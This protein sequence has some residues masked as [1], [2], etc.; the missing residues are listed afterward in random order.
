MR[1]LSRAKQFPERLHR[2]W[3]DLLKRHHVWVA[4]NYG[5]DQ[6]GLPIPAARLDIPRNHSH[7][8]SNPTYFYSPKISSDASWIL[9]ACLRR[10]R[11][12]PA[13]AVWEIH[14]VMKLK[15]TV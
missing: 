15:L 7:K 9:K 6:F 14:P 4:N 11:L 5:V 3:S 13:G 10:C 2:L 8:F 1:K 12:L